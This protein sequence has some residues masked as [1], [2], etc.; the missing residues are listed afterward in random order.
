MKIGAVFPQTEIQ[1]DPVIIKDFAQGVEALGFD[2][3]VAYDHIV[4][5]NTTDIPDWNMPYSHESSFQEPLM[6]FSYLA[7]VTSR[8]EFMPGVIILPQRQTTLVAKQAANLDI[9]SNGQLR[10]GVGIGWNQVEY[11]A[12]NESFTGKGPRMD[13]QMAFLRQCWTEETFVFKSDMHSM[14]NGGIKP[15]P[16]Q[17]PIPLWV[18]GFSEPAMRRAARLGDGWLP[19]ALPGD[20]AKSIIQKF[21][22]M[23]RDVGRDPASVPVENIIYMGTTLGDAIRPV[24]AAIEEALQWNSAGAYA[25]SFDTMGSNFATIDAH[26]AALEE[27]KVGVSAG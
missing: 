27:F 17:Q 22:A 18:G 11:E 23:V 14:N 1:S 21:E 15:L 24:A 4:G 3:L 20:K 5:K 9:Y 8:L 6:L 13:E 19:Y 12:L 10:L 2:H 16:K 25:V 7:G 26:L